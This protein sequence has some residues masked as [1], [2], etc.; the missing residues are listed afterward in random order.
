MLSFLSETGMKKDG[1][2]QKGDKPK[3][4]KTQMQAVEWAL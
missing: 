2:W 3:K 4:E 1:I